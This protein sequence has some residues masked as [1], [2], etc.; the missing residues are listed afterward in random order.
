[1]GGTILERV[2]YD[3]QTSDFVTPIK[4]LLNIDSS[5]GRISSLRQKLGRN[6]I[7]SSRLREDIEFVFMVATNLNARQIVPHLRFFRAEGVPIY[8]ISSVY[9]GK[10]NPQVDEDLNGV[11]FV[12]MPWLLRPDAQDSML[13]SQIEQSWQTSST[14]YPRYYAFGVDAFRIISQITDLALKKN[15]RYKGE[16]GSLYMTTDGVIHRN[17]LW[18]RFDNGLPEPVVPESLP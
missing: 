9:T 2:D 18:A 11:E 8:T 13:Q 3:P 14:I 16:T 7:T 6:L 15:Y 1:M 5:E 17:L 12:D 10:Q 4:Q